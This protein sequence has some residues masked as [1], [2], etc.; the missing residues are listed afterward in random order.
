MSYT[1]S[2]DDRFKADICKWKYP[3]KWILIWV[4]ILLPHWQFWSATKQ[5]PSKQNPLC[6][7]SSS[8]TRFQSIYLVFISKISTH[9]LF[10]FL[11]AWWEG[12]CVSRQCFTGYGL[13][14]P[15]TSSGFVLLT[16]VSQIKSLCC[17]L[18]LKC[19]P[20]HHLLLGKITIHMIEYEAWFEF[21]G[22]K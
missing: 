9:H 22:K 4:S 7:T 15:M 13:R 3:R 16:F 19:N 17:V 2:L 18:A 6:F 11:Y 14:E 8:L 1:S 5:W 10:F 20:T 21:G 12:I